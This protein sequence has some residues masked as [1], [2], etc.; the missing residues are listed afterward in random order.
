VAEPVEGA[1][2]MGVEPLTAVVGVALTASVGVLV[3][4][5]GAA[6]DFSGIGCDTVGVAVGP[7]GVR[8]AVRALVAVRIGVGVR[9]NGNVWRSGL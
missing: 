4:V 7:D 9:V 1:V 8:V 6:D 2:F 3:T 5:D